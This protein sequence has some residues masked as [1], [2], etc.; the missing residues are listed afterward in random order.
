M[1]IHSHVFKILTTS[2]DQTFLPAT[3]SGANHYS[4]YRAG[5]LCRGSQLARQTAGRDQ[6]PWIHSPSRLLAGE[7]VWFE[8]TFWLSQWCHEKETHSSF[9]QALQAKFALKWMYRSVSSFLWSCLAPILSWQFCVCLKA[10]MTGAGMA[11]QSLGTPFT[12]QAW[13]WSQA[14]QELEGSHTISGVLS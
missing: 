6:L 14:C 3:L 12:F 10:L 4:N 7:G 9:A 5:Q 1:N 13:K 11:S 8:E 2:H